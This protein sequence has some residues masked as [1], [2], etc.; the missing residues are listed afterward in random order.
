[1]RS[2]QFNDSNDQSYTILQAASISAN[3]QMKTGSS[4]KHVHP[5][6][7]V[8]SNGYSSSQKTE[9]FKDHI[10]PGPIGDMKIVQY[11]RQDS[12]SQNN[13]AMLQ[14]IFNKLDTLTALCADDLEQKTDE[15]L[16][17]QIRA[18]SSKLKQ[19]E[20]LEEFKKQEIKS[21]NE[22]L[23]DQGGTLTSNRSQ[24]SSK[25][26][27]QFRSRSRS[28]IKSSVSN[29][30]SKNSESPSGIKKSKSVQKLRKPEGLGINIKQTE[31]Q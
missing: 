18:F 7:T 22:P 9:E 17:E 5:L 15:Q 20:E 27:N 2:S 3:K 26:Q 30:Q 24:G 12:S 6:T 23:E 13:S 8:N 31:S 11:S 21:R 25:W 1:M 29:A 14:S 10:P 19:K 16:Q 4:G 28:G